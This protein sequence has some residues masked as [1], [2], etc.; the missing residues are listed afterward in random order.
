MQ[1][2]Q[3]I[4]NKLYWQVSCILFSI[5]I[6]ISSFDL[7]LSKTLI[8]RS[9]KRTSTSPATMRPAYVWHN[10]TAYLFCKTEVDLHS[11]LDLHVICPSMISKIF[12]SI[13]FYLLDRTC[14]LTCIT[15]LKNYPLWSNCMEY[16]RNDVTTTTKLKDKGIRISYLKC[17]N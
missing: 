5:T 9:K 6:F 15:S 8:S 13:L 1:W 14:K 4:L 17:Y 2:L 7:N 3:T 12:R 10:W 11:L 16:K